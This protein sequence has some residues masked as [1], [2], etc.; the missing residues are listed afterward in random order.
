MKG[1][2]L[3]IIVVIVSILYINTS[4]LPFFERK[5][6]YK[7]YSLQCSNNNNI[8]GKLFLNKPKNILEWNIQKSE[9]IQTIIVKGPESNEMFMII[10]GE[11]SIVDC[12]QTMMDSTDEKLNKYI[13]ALI[14]AP[15]LF[16]IEIVN[17]DGKNLIAKCTLN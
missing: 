15:E 9:N 13:V 17:K 8:K 2:F 6:T 10:C 1:L 3:L 14:N 7:E 4:I 5:L 11:P 12:A 16:T